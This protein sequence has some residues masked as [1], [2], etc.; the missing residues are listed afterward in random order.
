MVVS[1]LYIY[2]LSSMVAY[3]LPGLMLYFRDF[4][5]TDRH[6]RPPSCYKTMVLYLLLL[7]RL[8]GLL[9]ILRV[10]VWTKLNS[11]ETKEMIFTLKRIYVSL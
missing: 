5:R 11:H 2:F 9:S 4:R 1:W 7:G 6:G 3:R 8:S 10:R